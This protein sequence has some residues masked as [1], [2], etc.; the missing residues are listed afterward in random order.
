MHRQTE[1]QNDKNY[2]AKTTTVML[3]LTKNHIYTL[4][5]LPQS[6]NSPQHL[7]NWAGK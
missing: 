3:L 1:E 4:L 7:G 2:F 5:F 6:L